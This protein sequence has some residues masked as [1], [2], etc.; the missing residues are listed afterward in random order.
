MIG[1]NP[2]NLSWLAEIIE[3]R[4]ELIIWVPWKIVKLQNMTRYLFLYCKLSY[5]KTLPRKTFSIENEIRIVRKCFLQFTHTYIKVKKYHIYVF[6]WFV[7]KKTINMYL[8]LVIKVVWGEFL[9][10]KCVFLSFSKQIWRLHLF[11]HQKSFITAFKTGFSVNNIHFNFCGQVKDSKW[12][13]WIRK[14]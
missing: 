13:L 6:I 3:L 14:K 5:V 7:S 1:W 4:K 2:S 8:R 12:I 10:V 9:A 11:V